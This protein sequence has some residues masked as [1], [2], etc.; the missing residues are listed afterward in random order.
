MR[1]L[2]HA[3]ALFSWVALPGLAPAMAAHDVV[4]PLEYQVKA[5]YLFYFTRFVEWPATARPAAPLTVCVAAKN[6]FGT[7]L[8]DTMRRE[9]V[10]GRPVDARIV[11]QP[12]GCHVLFIP[13]DVPHEPYLRAARGLPMLTVG[14]SREFLRGGGI[15]NFLIE[16]GRVRFEIDQRA[17]ARAN[18]RISSRLLRLART[19][20][21]GTDDGAWLAR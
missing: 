10:N 11:R 4:A 7:A 3:L 17:A 6:P 12:G 8:A 2:I 21:P 20:A 18:L 16:N 13:H 9:Q 5:A 14:E 15:V 19:P 1:R